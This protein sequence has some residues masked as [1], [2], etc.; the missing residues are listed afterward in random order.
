[1]RT[2]QSF[3]LNRNR[4]EQSFKLLQTNQFNK[5]RLFQSWILQ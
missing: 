5:R 3:Q 4:K 2:I 1:M